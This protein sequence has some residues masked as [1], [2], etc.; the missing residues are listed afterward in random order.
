[1]AQLAQAQRAAERQR[2]TQVRASAQARRA[3]Q[4]ARAAYVRAQAADEREQKRLYVESQLA[5]VMAMN[6]EL[7]QSLEELDGVLRA[8][9]AVDD[10]LDL[11]T[12][13]HPERISPLDETPFGPAQ[14]APV[15]KAFMPEQPSVMGRMFGGAKYDRQFR[16]H[17][18]PSKS[19]M[20]QHLW[21]QGQRQHRIAA[22]RAKHDAD[23]AIRLTD[24][25]RRN[26]EVDDLATRLAA[27]V[28]EAITTYLNLVL[29]AAAYPEGFANEWRLAFVPDSAQLVVEFELPTLEVIP[30]VKTC[31]NVKTT[32]TK[33]V[34]SSMG[35]VRPTSRGGEAPAVGLNGFPH[36]PISGFRL[37]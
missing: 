33:S 32:D 36:A 10:Y 37:L 3:A 17:R 6:E 18:Q 23:G 13:K 12:L 4:Q 11:A 29:E 30:T 19:A 7:E 5:E 16:K 26:A 20:D 27:G 34:Y 8:T 35:S 1:M 31:K 2:A 15:L 24:I 9:L 14:P 22:A 25:R 21:A 28:P